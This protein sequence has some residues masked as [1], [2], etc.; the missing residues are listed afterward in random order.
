[1][2]NRVFIIHR[3]EANPESDWYP[4]LKSSLETKGFRV[5]VPSMPET[6]NPKIEK[7]VPFITKVVEYDDEQTY[8]VG[9]SVGCQM[10]LRHLELLPAGSKVGGVIL[11]AGFT[12]LTGLTPEEDI[13]ARPWTETPLDFNQV[14][15]KAKR[16]IGIFSDNDPFVPLSNA[17][18]FKNQ[19]DAKI[20]IE[21]QK[22]HLTESN[23]VKE[24]PSALDS[25]LELSS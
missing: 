16:F 10:I 11:V 3:W 12:H 4:W 17:D 22:G 14:K 23:D 24:L 9:H 25:L 19:L 20:I 2:A 8:F 1:M 7:W 18:V 15:I 6:K 5:F 21:K 13:I